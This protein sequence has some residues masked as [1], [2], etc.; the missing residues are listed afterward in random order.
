MNFYEQ[1]LKKI[2]GES[3]VLKKQQ[4]VGRK[5][6]GVIDGEIRGCVEFV[7]LG[8]SNQYAGIKASLLNRKEGQIDSMLI[9]FSDLFGKK[10]VHNPNFIDGIVPHIWEDG[11][12]PEWYVYHPEERDYK[13]LMEEVE[14]YF[15][16]FQEEVMAQAEHS[17]G[18]QQ[19]T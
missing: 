15:G 14:N 16:I 3:G 1:E 2:M 8:I 10:K 17:G 6:Y 11:G 13:Q 9:R 19:M 4:Y 18:M 5:C 12:K 7:T